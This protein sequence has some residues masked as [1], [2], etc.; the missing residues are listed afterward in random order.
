MPRFNPTA[1]YPV[2]LT[3]AVI[4]DDPLPAGRR[5][6]AYEQPEITTQ[7]G[8]AC[9]CLLRR[10]GFGIAPPL[11]TAAGALSIDERA[12]LRCLSL[13]AAHPTKAANGRRPFDRNGLTAASIATRFGWMVTKN[14]K[15]APDLARVRRLLEPLLA[16]CLLVRLGEGGGARY[17]TPQIAGVQLLA[18]GEPPVDQ[19]ATATPASVQLTLF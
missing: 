19:P 2:D 9:E 14:G 5:P 4:F 10:C 17:T 7:P 8:A 18:A 6:P 13:A 1:I 15:P 16:G 11:P 12:M 3:G